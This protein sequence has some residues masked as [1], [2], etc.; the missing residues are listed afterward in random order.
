MSY[1]DNLDQF[2]SGLD[3][4]AP[5][6]NH[7][8]T[9]ANNMEYARFLHDRKGYWVFNDSRVRKDVVEWLK[10]VID[11]G[12][13]LNDGNI[14]NALDSAGYQY[15]NHLQ[16]LT[17]KM[18]PPVKAGQGR[19][20]AHPGGWSDITGNLAGAFTH[21]VDDGREVDHEYDEN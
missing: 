9:F 2:L 16:S 13:P 14:I 19:R 15:I 6:E 20:S 7:K 10:K 18:R 8:I 12:M 1:S 11:A 21:Q 5:S 3:G 4:L 17:G